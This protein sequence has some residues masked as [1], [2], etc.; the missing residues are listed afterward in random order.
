MRGCETISVFVP[1]QVHLRSTTYRHESG[2]KT[3]KYN[4]NEDQDLCDSGAGLGG[5]KNRPDSQT[6]SLRQPGEDHHRD[7]VK[8][9]SCD[10]RDESHH[11]AKQKEDC[12]SS[13]KTWRRVTRHRH[14]LRD[15]HNDDVAE[16][17]NGEEQDQ[18]GEVESRWGI[19][20][21]RSFSN[22]YFA[23]QGKSLDGGETVDNKPEKW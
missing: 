21:A 7:H 15:R 20:V 19:R 1:K 11:P 23:L 18:L 14:S 13:T 3:A 8:E 17:D 2:E 4:E 5:L 22:K 16:R 10:V 6:K 12:V 9:E